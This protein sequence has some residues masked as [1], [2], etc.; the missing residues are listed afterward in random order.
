MTQLE[1]EN[2]LN[3]DISIIENRLIQLLPRC[4]NGQD[5]VV[6]AMRYSISNG[7][8]RLRPVLC[9]EFAKA[10]GADRYDA[11]DFACAVEFVHTYSLI[12]DDLPC[13]DNDDMRRGKP[14]CHKQFGEAVALLAGDALLTQAFQIL[15]GSSLDDSKIASACALLAQNSGVSGM[16]GGQVIDLKYES[17]TPDMKQILAVHRLKT[18]ALIAAACLLGCI[19]A[20]ADENKI[21]AASAYAYNLG[22]AFQIKDDILDVTG[23]TDE[24]GKPAGSDAQ[25]N[26]TTYVTLRGVENAQND[27]E[28]LTESAVARL[29]EFENTEFL[30]TLSYYLVNRNN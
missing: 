20:G 5:E 19:A 28:K 21:A 3:N 18:G 4:A 30:K 16:V 9:L 12:H 17:Q 2:I 14:S 25:N 27:V 11:L 23:S 7:G 13:M 6:E 15:S 26:K 8:K 1:F 29:D 24:L 22:V 10:C